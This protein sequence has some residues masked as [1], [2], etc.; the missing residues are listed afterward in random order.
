M[1]TAPGKTLTQAHSQGLEHSVWYYFEKA[2][3][4]LVNHGTQIDH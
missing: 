1:L 2:Q 3:A 4:M